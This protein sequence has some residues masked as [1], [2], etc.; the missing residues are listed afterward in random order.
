M[1]TVMFSY[2]RIAKLGPVTKPLMDEPVLKEIA[3]KHSKTVAQ[4]LLC[5][6]IQRGIIVVP[7]SVTPE[8]MR[9]NLEVHPCT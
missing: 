2:F 3:T 5:N 7:K 4:I 6:L 1:A 9:A 8:R